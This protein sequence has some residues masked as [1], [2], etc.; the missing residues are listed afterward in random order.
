MYYNVY[1]KNCKS[2]FN[3]MDI[4]VTLKPDERGLFGRE[5]NVC[6]DYFKTQIHAPSDEMLTGSMY[7]P[8]CKNKATNSDFMTHA[9][10]EYQ[11][12]V[13]E[14]HAQEFIE[15][16]VADMLGSFKNSKNIKITTR[17]T[18]THIPEPQYQDLELAADYSCFSCQNLYQTTSAP[19]CCPSCGVTTN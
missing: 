6:Q 1:I 19:T 12:R 16:S 7:C 2:E 15:T 3:V 10:R 14:K 8:Y 18:S 17:P 5:C 4:Q 9:Q 11:D 13:V